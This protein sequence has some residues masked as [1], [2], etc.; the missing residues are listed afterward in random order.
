[1]KQGFGAHGGF[2]GGL[3][4]FFKMMASMGNED[5]EDDDDDDDDAD[6]NPFGDDF[7]LPPPFAAPRKRGRGRA[8]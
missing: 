1:M 7:F 2:P 3:P 8:R 5:D 4:A 6:Y